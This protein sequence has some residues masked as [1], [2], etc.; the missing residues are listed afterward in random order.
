[1]TR[2]NTMGFTQPESVENVINYCRG[3]H[4]LLHQVIELDDLTRRR[5]G[6]H[7]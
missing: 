2:R 1:M 6:S 7:E 5:N 3:G 4:D